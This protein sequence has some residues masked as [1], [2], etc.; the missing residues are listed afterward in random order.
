MLTPPPVTV[1]RNFPFGCT[2]MLNSVPVK[3][4]DPGTGVKLPLVVLIA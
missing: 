1:K 2:R 4:G 3:N